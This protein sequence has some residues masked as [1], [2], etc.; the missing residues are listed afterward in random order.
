MAPPTIANMMPVKERILKPRFDGGGYPIV[1]LSING[2]TRNRKY[3]RLVMEDFIGPCPKGLEV[4]HLDGNRVNSRLD[5]LAYG[6]RVENCADTK[7]YDRLS[8]SDIHSFAKLNEAQVSEILNSQSRICRLARHYGVASST[9]ADIRCGRN[10]KH[11]KRPE[12]VPYVEISTKGEDNPFTKLNEEH[13]IEIIR[14]PL[15]GVVLANRYSVSADTIYAIR[16]GRSWKHIFQ[17]K[18]ATELAP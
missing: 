16:S 1:N 15:K 18:P 7:R 12:H 10:W 13:V 8:F 17:A 14:S 11:V 5:N 4:R 2:Q 9:V 3:H 6:T